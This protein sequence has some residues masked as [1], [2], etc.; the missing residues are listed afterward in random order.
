MTEW[1]PILSAQNCQT[2]KRLSSP[3][4][5]NQTHCRSLLWTKEEAKQKKIIFG[6]LPSMVAG[7]SKYHF[8]SDDIFC[9][10][11]L[12]EV[13]IRDMITG[14]KAQRIAQVHGQIL[15]KDTTLCIKL[16]T[17]IYM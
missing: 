16:S 13:K 1:R 2:L 17:F 5:P 9:I 14:M 12:W 15:N 8:T 7:D 3:T 10:L 4:N 11:I 6:E